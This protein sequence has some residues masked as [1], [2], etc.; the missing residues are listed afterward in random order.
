MAS[1][2]IAQEGPLTGLIL[3]L[4]D[5]Q[6]ILGRDA[7][8]A[9]FVL[10]EASVSR[11]HALLKQTE[12]GYTLENLSET[13]PLL[14]NGEEIKEARLL[15]ENDTVKIGETTFLFTSSK[16]EEQIAEAEKNLPEKE[17]LKED[18]KASAQ[19]EEHNPEEDLEEAIYDTIFEEGVEKD[20]P[21]EAL[22]ENGLNLKVVL[23]PN[24]G[25]EFA[26]QKGH[27]YIVGKDP[28][29]AD[30][31]FNDLSVSKN[32]A[33][34]SIEDDGTVYIEDLGAKNSTLVN[35]RKIKGKTKLTAKDLA[36]LGSSAFLISSKEEEIET[37][38]TPLPQE[39]EEE[40][41]EG[42]KTLIWKKRIIPSYYLILAG[43]AASVLFGL[44]LAFFSLFKSE[45]I[46]IVKKDYQEEIKD[47]LADFKDIS[48]SFN[49]AAYRLFL[50]GHVLTSVAQEE[51]M[52]KLK[53]LPFI[54][55][56]ENNII[57]DELVWKNMND[58]LLSYPS[59]RSVTVHSPKAGLFVVE[60]YVPTLNDAQHLTDY[61]NA[62]FPYLDK[63]QNNVNI[64]AVL[65]ISIGSQ[66]LAH[67][68]SNISFELN[69][70]ELILAGRYGSDEKE[71]FKKL[72]SYLKKQKGIRLI[73]N[74]AIET[75][76]DMARIDLTDKYH[77]SGEVQSDHENVSVVI[78]NK[79]LNTGDFIDDMKIMEIK[80]NT[81][82][83]EKDGLKY[84]INYKR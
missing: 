16:P 47:A 24:I 20:T 33:R 10:E 3:E 60:G 55:S 40:L 84:K 21:F 64:E 9:D 62:N 42:K 30:I 61:L 71:H 39:I 2:L 79:I 26:L 65:K 13:N 18:S 81:I 78:N 7:D 1:Y 32:H 54:E 14:V 12:E 36:H 57:I 25:A 51:M 83:L 50:T 58:M 56:I 11:K 4:E 34:I 38:Y 5:R 17:E 77:V 31:I 49:P 82:Y 29:T 22:P 43:L 45:K 44:S 67:G 76:P 53:A 6:Y 23:G 15:K 52:Y 28:S 41:E 35:S 8:I 68:L 48:F 63:L 59:F 70:G 37:I 73:K 74:I 19:A 27:S 72:I 75:T 66:I 80:T 46:E 69:S